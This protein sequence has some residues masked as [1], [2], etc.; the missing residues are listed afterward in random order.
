MMELLQMTYATSFSLSACAL[1]QTTIVKSTVKV[2]Y[3]I[4][5]CGQSYK[6]LY[7]RNLR[8]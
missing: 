3:E 4:D 2:L 7:G 5:H 8:L 6:A 1:F